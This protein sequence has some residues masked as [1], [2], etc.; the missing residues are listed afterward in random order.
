M[1]KE[2]CT[3]FVLMKTESIRVNSSLTK[4]TAKI[5][6]YTKT[7]MQNFSLETHFNQN[8]VLNSTDK[9]ASQPYLSNREA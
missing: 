4:N 5:T 8:G 6:K 1:I 2:T 3:Q 9:E 7:I